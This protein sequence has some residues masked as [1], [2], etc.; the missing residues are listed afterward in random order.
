M[1]NGGVLPL[2]SLVTTD[3]QADFDALPTDDLRREAAGY[4]LRLKRQP[5]LGLPLENLPSTGDLSDC[6]KVYFDEARYRIVY[7][8]LPDEIHPEHVEV[9]AIGPR[10]HGAVY[11]AALGRLGR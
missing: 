2:Q 10:Q 11:Q 6:R 8:L 9:I 1:S 3:V 5:F 7:R 4:L